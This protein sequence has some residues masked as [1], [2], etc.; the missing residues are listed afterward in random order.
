MTSNKKN[1]SRTLVMAI[2]NC[3]NDSFFAPSRAATAEI[4]VEKALLAEK[5]GA[6]II[7]VGGESTR[8]GAPYIDEKEE[9]ERV[10]PV[11]RGIR[12]R[13]GVPISVDTRKAVIAAAA[14]EAGANIINDIS[15]LEDDRD[16]GR[17]CAKYH[18]EVILMHKKGSP[19]TMQHEPFYHDVVTEVAFY[20]KDAVKR[21]L[22]AGIVEENII[23][24]PGI[25]FGK[26]LEDNT[27]LIRHLAAI[28]ALGYPVLAGLSRKTFIGELTGRDVPDRL[29]GTLAANAAAIMAGA[30]IIRVHDVKES[31]D[32][33]KV[34]N[35]VVAETA[36]NV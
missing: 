15:A 24:D 35:G 14:L 18:A 28:R 5:E 29:A 13:T 19:K 31:V 2:V 8:P 1:T 7:D 16:M 20:L 27:A 4:A 23:L 30:D 11:I 22:D 36:G 17:V 12:R 33:V 34:L 21:A 6:D 32:L 3:N 26:R 9:R 25:G 10:M